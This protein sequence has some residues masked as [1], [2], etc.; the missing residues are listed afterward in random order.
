MSTHAT[1]IALAVAL[2]AALPSVAAAT[3]A[4]R[5]LDEGQGQPPA[6]V[7][8]YRPFTGTDPNVLMAR[9]AHNQVGAVQ[10]QQLS[11][12]G[13]FPWLV[14]LSVGARSGS[15]TCSG[16]LISSDAVLT[17]AACVGA[18]VNWINA[19]VGGRT[20]FDGTKTSVTSGV[21]NVGTDLA[22]VKLAR[23]TSGPTMP[24]T[25]TAARDKGPNFTIPGWGSVKTKGSSSN[26]WRAEFVGASTVP[27]A[28]VDACG[29]DRGGPVLVTASGKTVQVGV[30][31][32]KS[33]A[34][35]AKKSTH[36]LISSHQGALSASISRLD[37]SAATFVGGASQPQPSSK[38][39]NTPQPGANPSATPAPTASS[40][41]SP[42]PD[43]GVVEAQPATPTPTE[44]SIASVDQ[45]YAVPNYR[46]STSNVTVEDNNAQHI[47]VTVDINHAC[48]NHLR[49]ELLTPS[50]QTYE[51]KQPSYPAQGECVA[52][53]GPRSQT[54]ALNG[55]P[56]GQ[57][58]LSI[59]DHFGQDSG[60][61]RSWSLSTD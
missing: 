43:T 8:T 47:T 41:T 7:T 34:S 17:S 31:S 36:V 37:A 26:T 39:P 55:Q 15:H 16:T 32:G 3:E 48:A 54:Y 46:S 23:A 1:R 61:V 51:L 53:D 59:S 27:G 11:D 58:G 40:E 60:T 5:E 57:W 56:T 44:E 38:A 45:S 30:L 10:A 35:A 4:P 29:D 49:I 50:G 28:L 42:A 6:A 21:L 18:D 13:S 33:C 14:K 2:L 9:N 24:L 25:S 22:V 19:Y 12:A 52:W 20:W